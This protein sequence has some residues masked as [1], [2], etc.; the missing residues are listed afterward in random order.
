MSHCFEKIYFDLDGTLSDSYL[1]IENGIRFALQ[2]VGIR[3]TTEQEIKRMIGMPL[4]QSLKT[5]YFQDQERIDLAIS[6]FRKYYA[7]KG[8]FESHLYPGIKVLLKALSKR[9]ELYVITAKPSVYASTLLDYHSVSDYFTEIKGCQLQGGNFSK[10]NL[11]NEVNFGAKAIMIG[12]KKQD[13]EAGKLSKIKTCGVKYGYA[14][15]L[16]LENEN[17]DFLLATVDELSS[18]L[19]N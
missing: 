11:I 17:P 13:I 8:I 6:E 2:Q 15:P 1:G 14:S 5:Y 7:E 19:L 16:E 9:A 10:S 4:N 12:D 18:L 3:A